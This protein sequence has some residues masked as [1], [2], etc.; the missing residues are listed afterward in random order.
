RFAGS[1]TGT[2]PRFSEP[3]ALA[4]ADVDGDGHL[5]LIAGFA[6]STTTS[7]AVFRNAGDSGNVLREVSRQSLPF[8][9]DFLATGDFNADGLTDVIAAARGD[10]SVQLFEGTGK[11]DFNPP[12]VINL[13]G[14]I[15]ALASG[16]INRPDGVADLA[17]GLK[18][19][20][21]FSV[22]VFSSPE[23]V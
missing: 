23:G 3:I 20:D 4:V 19:G 15:T 17:V 8:R 2:E 14:R 10:S 6:Y 7:L 5:D 9:P 16:E 12:R 21:G 1:Q 18:R 13:T 22:A 11:G